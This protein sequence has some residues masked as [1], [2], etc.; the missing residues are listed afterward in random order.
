MKLKI[1]YPGHVQ[2]KLFMAECAKDQLSRPDYAAI[3]RSIRKDFDLTQEQVS[4]MVAAAKLNPKPFQ[5]ELKLLIAACAK[6]RLSKRDY[7]AIRK[8]IWTDVTLT[9]EELKAMIS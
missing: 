1:E 4:A 9:Q 6:D 3:R 5:I 8:C 7:A 2:V